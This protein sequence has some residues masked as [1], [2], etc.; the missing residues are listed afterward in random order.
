[1]RCAPLQFLKN[2]VADALGVPAQMRIPKPQDLDSLCSQVFIT[3][4]IVILPV[5][6]A[7][8]RTVELDGEARFLAKE[9]KKVDSLRMLAAE[10]VALKRRSRSQCHMSFSAQVSFLRSTRARST[11]DMMKR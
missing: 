11:L 7:V 3:F 4:G 6:M 2:R 9:I 1:M 10:F 5:G 8:A